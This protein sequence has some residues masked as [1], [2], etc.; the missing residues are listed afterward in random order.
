MGDV[1]RCLE[2]GW[3]FE[4]RHSLARGRRHGRALTTTGPNGVPF[5]Q[6]VVCDQN[7]DQIGNRAA[8]ERL[9]VLVDPERRRLAAAAVVLSPFTPMLF[10]GEEYGER[11]PFPFF[12]DHQDPAIVEATRTGRRAEFPEFE[13]ESIPDPADPAT[14]ESAV[15]DHTVMADSPHRE[16][17]ELYRDLLLHRRANRAVAAPTATTTVT[18]EGSTIFVRRHF[19]DNETM[20]ALHFGDTPSEWAANNWTVVLDTSDARYGGPGS[21]GEGLLA[22]WSAQFAHRS[23]P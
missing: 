23:R 8:G 20:L 3:T 15:L 21:G 13:P 2:A 6:L 19:D 11:A 4:G 9:D 5:H 10:M 18:S 12:I 14:F 16:V 17:L 1:Q 22:P 7:H